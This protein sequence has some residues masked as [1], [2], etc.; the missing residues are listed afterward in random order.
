MAFEAEI[1]ANENALSAVKLSGHEL[2]NHGHFASDAI[3]ARIEHLEEQW[4]LLLEKS[5]LKERKLREAQSLLAFK[6][7]ADEIE[8]W[9][10]S[11]VSQCPNL[12]L[13]YC[14]PAFFLALLFV[15]F[16]FLCVCVLFVCFF[17]CLRLCVHFAFHHVGVQLLAVLLHLLLL[18]RK[19]LFRRHVSGGDCHLQRCRQGS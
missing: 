8:T 4:A 18:A 1:H 6:R 15:G 13:L 16:F 14:L 17:V 2:M 10:Q 7:E 11:K 9:I 12:L 3:A 5:K 19:P